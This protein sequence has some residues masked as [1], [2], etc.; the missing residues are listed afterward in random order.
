MKKN[1]LRGIHYRVA[2]G[3]CFIVSPPSVQFFQV[4]ESGEEVMILN[5]QKYST[6]EKANSQRTFSNKKVGRERAIS[7][8][9]A[10]MSPLQKC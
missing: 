6:Y 8:T 5:S 7:K 1:F 4:Y 2:F 10:S 9:I 3:A